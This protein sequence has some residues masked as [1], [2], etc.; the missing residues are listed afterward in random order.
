MATFLARH[1][2][3]PRLRLLC[4]VPTPKNDQENFLSD[5]SPDR[6]LLAKQSGPE[7]SEV[8]ISWRFAKRWAI[9]SIGSA[10]STGRSDPSGTRATASSCQKVWKSITVS[11]DCRQ[12][13]RDTGISCWNFCS[14][15]DLFFR[16]F[17]ELKRSGNSV[18]LKISRRNLHR[19]SFHLLLTSF[20]Q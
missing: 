2:R 13:G 9:W 20:P 12:L 16:S 17:P 4:T 3:Q 10:I 15:L 6:S 19:W 18:W 1:I 8:A 5:S 14:G 11:P 7:R